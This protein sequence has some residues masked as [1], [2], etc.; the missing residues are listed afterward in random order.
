MNPCSSFNDI[1]MVLAGALIG[2][3]VFWRLR[4]PLILGY[5]LAGLIISPLTPGIRVHDVHTFEMMAEVGVMLLMFSIG[6]EFLHSRI[7]SGEVGRACWRPNGS[8][9]FADLVSGWDIFLAGRFPKA[10]PLVASFQS[11]ARW[12]LTRLAHPHRGELAAR[13]PA[14]S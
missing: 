13:R 3:F 4:Q 9:S 1:A 6:I 7:A 10:L 5:V 8:S 14:A 2:G 11:P 12:S